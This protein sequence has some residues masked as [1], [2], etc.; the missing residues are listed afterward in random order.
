MIPFGNLN[1]I[2][3]ITA[4]LKLQYLFKNSQ[5]KTACRYG[6]RF[7]YLIIYYL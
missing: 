5:H 4:K 3:Y 2:H 7:M 1:F 6:K